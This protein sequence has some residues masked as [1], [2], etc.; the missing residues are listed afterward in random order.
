MV[1]LTPENVNVQG[2]TRCEGERLEDVWEHLGG[3]VSNLLAF[4]FE[5]CN[6][7]WASR[8]VNDGS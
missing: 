8:D 2:D 7:V 1:I 5:I 6:A 4:H 3:E